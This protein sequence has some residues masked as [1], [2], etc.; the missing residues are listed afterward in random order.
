MTEAAH[1]V[2]DQPPLHI[3]DVIEYVTDQLVAL[4]VLAPPDCPLVNSIES[5]LAM[6]SSVLSDLFIKYLVYTLDLRRYGTV[7]SHTLKQRHCHCY[8]S[9]IDFLS[10]SEISRVL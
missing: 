9:Q 3:N 2:T 4:L 6:K 5:F 1:A 10:I 8:I 7:N